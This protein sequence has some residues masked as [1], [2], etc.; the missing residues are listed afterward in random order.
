MHR[1]SVC[2]THLS[3]PYPRGGQLHYQSLV[4]PS[5]HKCQDTVIATICFA[6]ETIHEVCGT[7]LPADVVPF[8]IRAAHS[9][10]TED[11]SGSPGRRLF[12]K[13]REACE[14][15]VLK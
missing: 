9:L 2:R 15:H 11:S 7:I 8:R 13:D 3:P 1:H 4:Y 10:G 6:S 14:R 12:K 5:R